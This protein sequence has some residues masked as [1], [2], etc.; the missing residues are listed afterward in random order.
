R[1]DSKGTLI[2]RNSPDSRVDIGSNANVRKRLRR[3]S[4]PDRPGSGAD[5]VVIGR[6]PPAF[7]QRQMPSPKP[8]SRAATHL[9]FVRTARSQVS[10]SIPGGTNAVPPST[11][12]EPPPGLLRH[13]A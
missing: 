12:G 4:S 11:S 13:A 9:R 7:W 6:A 8:T 5:G 1:R 10:P 3:G 2:V